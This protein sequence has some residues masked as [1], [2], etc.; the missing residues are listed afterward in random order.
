MATS[1]GVFPLFGLEVVCLLEDLRQAGDRVNDPANPGK[2]YLCGKGITQ[3]A[4]MN[5][6]AAG[7]DGHG[8]LDRLRPHRGH[9]RQA[10]RRLFAAG[11]VE[12]SLTEGSVKAAVVSRYGVPADTVYLQERHVAQ[13]FQEALF[14]A[15]AAR[16]GPAALAR[17]LGTGPAPDWTPPASRTPSVPI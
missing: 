1:L 5:A 3:F 12:T 11:G 16:G 7:A 17:V 10:Q 2:T 9:D 13:A 15:V 8:P 14:V 4:P 6:A